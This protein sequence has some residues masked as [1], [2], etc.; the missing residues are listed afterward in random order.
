MEKPLLTLGKYDYNIIFPIISG[1]TSFIIYLIFF[2][3][4][5]PKIIDFPIILSFGSCIGMNFSLILFIMYKYTNS[6]YN[7]KN[8][9]TNQKENI[10]NIYL[11]Y[12]AQYLIFLR[13][14]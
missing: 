2:I 11:Y 10:L 8:I 13:L 3:F 12:Y 4:I 5:K 1:I 7:K 9:K 14:F 6:K